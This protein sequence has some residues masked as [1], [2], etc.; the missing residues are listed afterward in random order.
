MSFTKSD[1][2]DFND[3]KEDMESNKIMIRILLVLVALALIGG[4][5]FLANHIFDLQWF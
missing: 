4:I 2:D 1:F 5:V 3:L